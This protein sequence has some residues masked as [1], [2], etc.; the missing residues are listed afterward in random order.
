[1]NLRSEQT[2]KL[3]L[4]ALGAAGLLFVYF[5]THLLP[6]GYAVRAKE[7][8]QLEEHGAKLAQDLV[9]A[10]RT[11]G[12]LPALEAEHA[13]LQAKW[14]QAQRLLPDRT[15]IAALLRDITQCGLRC[16]V[17]FTLFKP[18]PAVGH[19]F[20]SEKPI[21]VKV[22]GG[23]HAIARFLAKLA[24][25]DRIVHV[26]DLEIEQIPESDEATQVARARFVAVA[27]LLGVPPVS[28]PAEASAGPARKAVAAAKRVVMGRGE[29]KAAGG[30]KSAGHGRAGVQGGSEE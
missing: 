18:Q 26:R 5:G 28:A 29:D 27:Y 3:I 10:R 14:E 22:E 12:R 8:G 20:Y 30:A 17:D 21:E 16:G 7:I 1:M 6:I 23:Y 13:A 9:M 19:D 25:M 2:G 4:L 24:T 15:E 11:A